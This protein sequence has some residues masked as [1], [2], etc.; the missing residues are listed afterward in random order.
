VDDFAEI[1]QLYAR[2]SRTLDEKRH[3][4]WLDCFTED[5][6]V[7]GPNFGRYGG[8]EQ[9]RQFLVKYRSETKMF[10]M[11][12]VIS[13]LEVEIQGDSATGSCYILHY[14]TYRGHPELSAIGS[15]H[16]HLRK[17]GGKWLFADR[18]ATWDY[19]GSPA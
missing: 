9:L 13:N 7:E 1:Q 19:S 8:R 16:D 11:R 12:H 2:Y 17:V 14:R 6:V 15:Y 10:Q 3:E 5:G 18:K 4:E